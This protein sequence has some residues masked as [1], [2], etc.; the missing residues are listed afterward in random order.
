MYEGGEYTVKKGLAIL[1]LLTMIVCPLFSSLA[2]EASSLTTEQRNAIA[3]LNYIT[4]LTQEINASKNSRLSMEEAYS[5]LINNTYPN[6]VDSRTLSQ[7][8]QL[9]D[10]MENSRMV[11][12][13]R[14]RL[15]YIYEQNQAQAIRAAIPN[16]LGLLNS[17]HSFTP[18]KMISSIVYMAVDSATSYNAY[19]EQNDLKYLED[20]WALEEEEAENLHNS[21]KG[22][23]S[24]MIKMVSDYNIPGDTVLTESSVEEFV[25]WKHNENVV[26]RIHFLE[27]NQKTYKN[28]G[29]YWLLLAESYYNNADYKNCIDALSSYEQLGTRIFRRDY[30]LAKILPLAIASAEEICKIEEYEQLASRYAQMIIDNTDHDDWALRYFAAQ[31]FVNL[32]GKTNNRDYLQTAYNITLDNVNYLVDEQKALNNTY[33]APVQEIAIPKNASQSEKTQIEKYNTMLKETRKTE[34]PPIHEP[35]HLNCDLLFA[36]IQKLDISESEQL[37]IDGILHPHGEVTFLNAPLDSTYWCIPSTNT[38]LDKGIIEYNGTAMRVSASLVTKDSSILVSIRDEKAVN[39]DHFRDW[40]ITSINRGVDGKMD[41]IFVIYSSNE[42]R[43]HPWY[44]NAD[45]WI[46]ITPINNGNLKQI[47]CQYKSVG[48]KNEWYD[49]FKVW[50]GQNNEWYDCLKV[51]DNKVR[52]ERVK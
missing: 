25:K 18:G 26:S 2:E 51:W 38:N 30:S 28:Y 19:T 40:K 49:W 35:L 50:E 8:N 14:E 17:T 43:N 13:K 32:Y 20:G 27:S 46:Y 52:F 4:V 22:T 7:L 31:T 48:M 12:V 9:L 44:P 3:M 6:A 47:E 24:Y 42:V 34:L 45:I 37:K 10:T 21:R 33:L 16:P 39:T 1:I 11:S 15:Q 29:G 36:L 5:A 23:F 41:E